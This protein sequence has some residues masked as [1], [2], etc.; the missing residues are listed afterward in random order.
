MK[1]TV[2]K[3]HQ[4][5]FLRRPPH[6]PISGTSCSPFLVQYY[7]GRHQEGSRAL[8]LLHR[9]TADPETFL[10]R[11]RPFVHL[12]RCDDH[13]IYL[14]SPSCLESPGSRLGCHST[15]IVSLPFR[16]AA[17]LLTL[18]CPFSIVAGCHILFPVSDPRILSK[19]MNSWPFLLL[20]DHPESL[21]HDLLVLN[22][23]SLFNRHDPPVFSSLLAAWTLGFPKYIQVRS[24]NFSSSP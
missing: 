5:L 11:L 13:I 4:L 2:L 10:A 15:F 12:Y 16:H 3:I 24:L 18:L 1:L 6:S 14:T 20:S 19:A 23:A 17:W 22:R 7:M 8:Q 21:A 9:G